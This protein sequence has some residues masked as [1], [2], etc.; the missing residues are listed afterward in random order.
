MARAMLSIVGLL[1][2]AALLVYLFFGWEVPGITT[3]TP[4]MEQSARN[5]ALL[6]QRT[7]AD[8]ARGPDIDTPGGPSGGSA[9]ANAPATAVTPGAAPGPDDASPDA[10]PRV[11]RSDTPEIISP[12]STAHLNSAHIANVDQPTPAWATPGSNGTNSFDP[13]PAAFV[14]PTPLP[15]HPQWTWEVGN[16]EFNNVVVTR[17]DADM[18]AITSDSGPTQIDIALLSADLQRQ[19][20]YSP[21]LAAEAAAARKNRPANR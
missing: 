16:R 21:T 5:T 2:T 9:P 18:V 20:N 19:L 14:A 17:V 12:D 3:V 6:E 10:A 13:N 15:A 8:Y 7:A 11:V 4:G 1:V